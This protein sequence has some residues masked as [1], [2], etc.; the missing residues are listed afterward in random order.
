[1]Q[2]TVVSLLAPMSRGSQPGPENLPDLHGYPRAWVHIH[3]ETYT[4][5]N[6]IKKIAASQLKNI[7]LE[8]F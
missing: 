6:K 4:N 7:Q 1:M 5:T 3:I 2:M 8:C